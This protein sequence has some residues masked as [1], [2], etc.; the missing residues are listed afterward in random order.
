MPSLFRPHV[1]GEMCVERMRIR[2][3][4]CGF[5][6]RCSLDDSHAVKILVILT[7]FFTKLW[8]NFLR[9]ISFVCDSVLGTQGQQRS[10]PTPNPPVKI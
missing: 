9:S 8:S 6:F 3:S 10:Y 5:V 7:M 1:F 2:K 4:G